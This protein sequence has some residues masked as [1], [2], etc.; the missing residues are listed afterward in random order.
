MD[1]KEYYHNME[2]W[3][4]NPMRF[5]SDYEAELKDMLEIA[6]HFTW[7][8]LEKQE[9]EY[10]GITNMY[11]TIISEA[12]CYAGEP[13]EKGY[14]YKGISIIKTHM[15]CIN[16]EY[17]EHI[18][19]YNSYEKQ[20]Q[21]GNKL[22]PKVM[23][24]MIDYVKL[25]D[26]RKMEL[27]FC[28]FDSN[29]LGRMIYQKYTALIKQKNPDYRYADLNETDKDEKYYF[30]KFENPQ[31]K[32]LY[33]KVDCY[34]SPRFFIS[35]TYEKDFNSMNYIE[36]FR[37]FFENGNTD[38][39]LNKDNDTPD[40]SIPFDMDN[41]DLNYYE[42]YES[43]IDSKFPEVQ[44]SDGEFELIYAYGESLH[45]L[46]PI[47][48]SFQSIF[49]VKIDP[50]SSTIDVKYSNKRQNIPKNFWDKSINAIHALI[51]QNGSGKSSVF[52]LLFGCKL[53]VPAVEADDKKYFIIYKYDNEYYYAN[54]TGRS[55]NIDKPS[56]KLTEYTAQMDINTCLISNVYELFSDYETGNDNATPDTQ[57]SERMEPKG[58]LP[59]SV[60]DLT[61]QSIL[62]DNTYRTKEDF[63]KESDALKED[64]YR[65]ENLKKVFGDDL[66][67]FSI[68]PFEHIE[69]L[70]SGE[71]TRVI[72][73]ARL[74]S[75]FY[76]DDEY[77]DKLPNI[78]RKNNYLILLDEA[79]V[80]MHPAWQKAFIHDLIMFIREINNK[81]DDKHK[82]ITILLS[83]NSPF[84]MSDL[85]ASNIH[86]LGGNM[87]TKTFGQNIYSILK[88]KFFMKDGVVGN[89]A[90]E[91]IDRAFELA[92]PQ[93]C[94][95][96]TEED[97]DYINYIEDI[98]GDMIMKEMLER[99][100]DNVRD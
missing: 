17:L 68:K 51:G 80:Y 34:N 30:G 36:D 29:L 93:N 14:A 32:A 40:L 10:E 12:L 37:F 57:Q 87:N 11:L 50:E 52:K 86:L 4:D 100:M 81:D 24:A 49:E 78:E 65:I 91:K 72:I 90:N 74:L 44:I 42:Q 84:M 8:E 20:K 85:P 66:M 88:D 56:V 28:F 82:N 89:F 77:K 33:I 5:F 83:S 38:I 2:K 94:Q 23:R 3:R 73:F 22:R 63:L 69:K 64:R 39:Y 9:K 76:V 26:H 79:E 61:T 43:I 55:V 35:T 46:P 62:Y 99:R 71:K 48:L 31:G 59:K 98:L 13:G 75:L 45:D 25:P 21:F 92:S 18:F 27:K 47:S 58:R 1:F 97:S 7:E 54:T 15:P 67:K 41:Y 70:S 96:L 95:N 6:K 16:P 53:F 60:I 19:K